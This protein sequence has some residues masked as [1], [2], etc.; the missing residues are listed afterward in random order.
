MKPQKATKSVYPIIRE[1]VNLIPLEL[2]KASA[3]KLHMNLDVPNML[4]NF[5]IVEDAAHHDSV[6]AEAATAN[7]SKWTLSFSRLAGVVRS[8][9]WV[10]RRIVELLELYG[11]ASPG[12]RSRFPRLYRGFGRQAARFS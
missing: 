2:V 3:A 10:R 5:A 4:P 1:L 12:S 9:L 8:A 7:L 11:T 6:R